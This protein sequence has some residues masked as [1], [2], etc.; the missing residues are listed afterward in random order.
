MTGYP[1]GQAGGCEGN[2]RVHELCDR[3]GANVY[4]R[5]LTC[6]RDRT[7]QNFMNLQK[8]KLLFIGDIFT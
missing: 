1:A 5:C 2:P 4:H 6:D 3:T 8:L 7:P